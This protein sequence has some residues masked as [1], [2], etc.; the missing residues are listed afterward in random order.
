MRKKRDHLND[1]LER[2]IQGEDLESCLKDYPEEAKV[3]RPLLETA[4]RIRRYSETA[5]LS[6]QFIT[7]TQAKLGMAYQQKYYADKT[8]IVRILK[9]L[10]RLSVA[11]AVA[12]AALVVTFTGGFAL[13][14][15]ASENIMPGEILYPVKLATEQVRLTFAF[16][17]ERKTSYLSQFAETRAEEIA[18]SVEKNDNAQVEAALQRLEGNLVKVE[19]IVGSDKTSSAITNSEQESLELEKIESIVKDSSAKVKDKMKEIKEPDPE[20]KDKL[21]QRV[22]KAYSKATEAIEKAKANKTSK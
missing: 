3:L 14:V 13:S 6:P 12:I 18:Y 19:S 22:E 1:C 4:L 21:T 20:K 7:Q 15:Q 8:R 17:D 5:K 11:T 16:S 10:S 9:P 2:L